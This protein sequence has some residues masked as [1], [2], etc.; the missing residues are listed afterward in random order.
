MKL[1]KTFQKLNE[2]TNTD[3]IGEENLTKL[4]SVLVDDPDLHISLEQLMDHI[5][6]SVLVEDN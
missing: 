3:F 2:S 6:D 1:I 5:S 4:H